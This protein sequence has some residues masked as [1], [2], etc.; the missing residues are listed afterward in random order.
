MIYKIDALLRIRLSEPRLIEMGLDLIYDVCPLCNDGPLCGKYTTHIYSW[1][2]V[3]LLG[4]F[5]RDCFHLSFT[6]YF[7]FPPVGWL[8]ESVQMQVKV[9]SS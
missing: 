8:F 7:S 2:L 9:Q 4:R 1:H 6:P 5:Q 3:Q